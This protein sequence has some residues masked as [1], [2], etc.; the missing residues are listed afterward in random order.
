MLDRQLHE[1]NLRNILYKIYSDPILSTQ[2]AFKGGTCLYMFYNLN[3]FSTDLD[4]NSLTD[5]LDTDKLTS[6]LGEY[7]IKDINFSDKRFTWFWLL[8]YKKEL[9]NIKVEVSKRDY[10]DTYETK[11]LLGITVRCMT[12]DCMFAHKLCAITDRKKLVNRDLYDT[13]FM[14][15]NQFPI[16]EEIIKIRMGK[17]LK[18]YL[19]YLVQFIEKNVIEKNILDGLGEVL[20]EKTKMKVKTKLKS[21]L[22][23]TLKNQILAIK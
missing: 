23:F 20:D 2:L 7:G 6:V 1:I 11:D 21:E 3:R 18:E 14:F 19:E 12:Q 9:M 16:K 17:T 13:L 15:Q 10:P 22:L 5:S 4:F 8:N